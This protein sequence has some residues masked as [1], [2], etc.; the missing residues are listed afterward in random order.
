MGVKL[1]VGLE[2]NWRIPRGTVSGTTMGFKH[3]SPLTLFIPVPETE[4]HKENERVV[5]ESSARLAGK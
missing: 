3:S 5:T 1:A 4:M 2:L